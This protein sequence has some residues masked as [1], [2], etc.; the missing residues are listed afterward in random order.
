MPKTIAGIPNNSERRVSGGANQSRRWRLWKKDPHCVDCG[1]LCD[2]PSGYELDHEIPLEQGGTEH[3]SNL[4]IRC[5]W[6][7]VDGTKR[8]CH[9]AKTQRERKEVGR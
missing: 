4:K 1:R 5:V 3:E 9:E 7:D 6:W 2:H 8:G